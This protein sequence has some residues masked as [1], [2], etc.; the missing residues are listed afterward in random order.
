MR[1]L[2]YTVLFEPIEDGGYLVVVPALPG[3]VTYGE[4]LD[5]ARRM[6]AEAIQCHCE[7]LLK[8]G[9]EL[10]TDI[11]LKAEPIREKISISLSF[12]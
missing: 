10:P 2:D 6:A 12:V 8:D 3:I 9:E 1:V 5:E 11:N 7:G 4:N